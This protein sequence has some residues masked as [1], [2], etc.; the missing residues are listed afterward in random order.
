MYDTSE[1]LAALISSRICHDLAS[2]LG[3]I[4]NGIELL[5]LTG[6][7]DTPEALL[8]S[9]S[10]KSATAR[11]EFFRIA[12]GPAK[13]EAMVA[14]PI[15]QRTLAQNYE[16]RKI[17]AH[18]RVLNDVPRPLVK[19]LFLLV[20]TAETTLPFGGDI[21]VSYDHSI[22][23]IEC[24]GTEI[25]YDTPLWAVLT[26][27]AEPSEIPSSRVQFPLARAEAITQGLTIDVAHSDTS[28]LIT[29][30]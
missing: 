21:S 7:G 14:P 9:D 23:Q 13:P 27:G 11:L 12:Y 5:E 18:W 1:K 3:A 4:A 8:L 10:V 22:A 15:A 29:V 26:E 30:R 16:E 19:L 24:Q 28:L 2:P 6:F 25:R 17:T 20:Q